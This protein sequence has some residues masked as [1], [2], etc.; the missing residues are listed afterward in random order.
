MFAGLRRI[1]TPKASLVDLPDELLLDILN[2]LS[3]DELYSVSFHSPRLHF[4][5]IP[6]Y[7][8]RHEILDNDLAALTNTQ[9]LSLYNGQLNALPGVLLL[10]FSGSIFAAEQWPSSHSSDEIHPLQV[11]VERISRIK[12]ITL[13]SEDIDCWSVY[14]I[15]SGGPS[16]PSLSLWNDAIGELLRVVGKEHALRLNVRFGKEYS[17]RRRTRHGGLPSLSQMILKRTS[18]VWPWMER[19]GRK[20]SPKEDITHMKGLSRRQLRATLADVFVESSLRFQRC[21]ACIEATVPPTT[22]NFS[23]PLLDF[24][25]DA[26]KMILPSVNVPTLR[27]L[28]IASRTLPLQDLSDFLERHPKIRSLTLV[29]RALT[30][31]KSY[32]TFSLLH[33]TAMKGPCDSIVN[34]LLR[35]PQI[36]NLDR[37]T[38][39]PCNGSHLTYYHLFVELHRLPG[40][41]SLNIRDVDSV[42][43]RYIRQTWYGR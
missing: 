8:S 1:A 14:L 10:A 35:S 38:I 41:I 20:P 12:H 43:L 13:D 4:L 31:Q 25:G 23:F 30:F 22:N 36:P 9:G 34:L 32:Q 6:M 37:L 33:L 21:A 19:G 29:G 17:I 39:L 16:F 3:D 27:R 2:D 5:S 42:R 18:I 26:W 7:L 11:L 15:L 28:S 40:R 24:C